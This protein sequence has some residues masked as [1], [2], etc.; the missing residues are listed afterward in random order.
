[1]I[2]LKLILQSDLC[3]GSGEA[4]GMTVDSDICMDEH[5]FPHIP[6]RRL[7]G[8]LRDAANLLCSCGVTT[9]EQ[10]N[11]LFGVSAEAGLFRI[12]DA[13]LPDIESLRA[14]VSG[15]VPQELARAAAPLNV[16]RLFTSIRGQ[17]ALENGV[18]KKGALRFTRVLDRHNA[19]HPERE[20]ALT[21]RVD[22]KPGAD[23]E[24]LMLCCKAVRHIGSDRNRGLGNVRL[25]YTEKEE[26]RKGFQPPA[27]PAAGDR[28]R[29]QCGILCHIM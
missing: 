8:V 23:S 1:M 22:L 4:T 29:I 10:V 12:T 16:S 28:F 13:L 25:E 11:A 15:S 5:G 2:E 6:A 19:L 17:T 27:V 21:A 14:C 20:T 26:P 18:A 24:L 7:K 3:A 9:E